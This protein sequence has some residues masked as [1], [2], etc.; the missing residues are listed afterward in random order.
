MSNALYHD[1]TGGSPSQSPMRN[2]AY[3]SNGN[4]NIPHGNLTMADMHGQ[5]MNLD[6][7]IQ[8]PQDYQIM[9]AGVSIN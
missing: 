7:N 9:T 2:V 1:T 3:P 8:Y 4:Q 5:D 6:Q